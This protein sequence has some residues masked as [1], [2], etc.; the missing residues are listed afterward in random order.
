MADLYNDLP[1]RVILFSIASCI[2]R[3]RNENSKMPFGRLRSV[4]VLSQRPHKRRIRNYAVILEKYPSIERKYKPRRETIESLR[5]CNCLA[6]HV[7]LVPMKGKIFGARMT[8]ANDSFMNH[9]IPISRRRLKDPK[10]NARKATF[11]MRPDSR[12]KVAWLQ[13][14]LA[15]TEQD[16]WSI[17]LFTSFRHGRVLTDTFP[18]EERWVILR[19]FVANRHQKY[20]LLQA[21]K[22]RSQHY[23]LWLFPCFEHDAQE[24]ICFASLLN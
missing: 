17:G 8:I 16:A 10:L 9:R 5:I 6:F 1:Q 23:S 22:R 13:S 18:R 14:S 2:L 12:T 4:D 24:K 3:K 11:P 20:F 15:K 19:C 21:C 7:C